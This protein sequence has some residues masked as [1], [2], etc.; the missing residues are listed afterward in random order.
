MEKES[1]CLRVQKFHGE[2]TIVLANKFGISNRELEIKKDENFVYVPLVRQ[3]TENEMNTL[4]SRSPET[5]LETQLF[6]ERKRQPKTY[7]EIL[8]NQLPPHLLASL[9]R[10]LDIVG[11]IAIVEIPPELEPYA[12][13]I[14]EAVLEKYRNI[15]TVLA[16]AGAVG[17]TFR[18]REFEVIAGEP[19]TATVHKEFGCNYHVDVAKAYFSPRLSHEHKRVA[20][21]VQEGESVV[22]LF[23]GIGPFAVL[24][25]KKV[26]N[27]KV[28]A[29]DVNPDAIEFLKKN[30][31]LNRVENKVVPILGDARK[32]V[33]ET[34]SG[35]ADRVIMN[36]PEKAEEFVDVACLAIKPEGGIIHFYGFSRPSDSAEDK[37]TRFS[38]AV[39]NAGRRVER[40][41]AVKTVRETAPHEWQT[42]LDVKIR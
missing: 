33:L 3:P 4:M 9:P 20:E 16:K 21:Q 13:L 28:Y 7:A 30:I 37:K 14:G 31:R 11:E 17:G 18:L 27:V 19:K 32:I 23:A 35:I 1:L 41:L 25:A 26:G 2:K 39:E 10:A 42:V 5:L 15:Q 6:H 29:I 12:K 8:E 40:F 22:D 24:I 38:T 34:L 36:L